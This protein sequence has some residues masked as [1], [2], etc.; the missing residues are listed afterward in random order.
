MSGT[1]RPKNWRIW[2]NISGSTGLIF[3]IFTPHESALGADNKYGPYFPIWQGMLPWQ[4]NNVAVM[5][6]N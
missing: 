3:A 4:P 2:S 5:K 1:T 6:A